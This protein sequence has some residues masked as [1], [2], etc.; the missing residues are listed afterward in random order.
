MYRNA[1][2]K[3]RFSPYIG[4]GLVVF[5]SERAVVFADLTAPAVV[6]VSMWS[7]GGV[8]VGFMYYLLGKKRPCSGILYLC[9]RS[10]LRLKKTPATRTTERP[11]TAV[12]AFQFLG[13]EYQPP[14]GDQ[15]CLG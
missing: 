10:A 8:R 1:G 13:C 2:P 14:A 5:G 12:L 11:M 7:I 15:T 6:I 3:L 4:G 9:S